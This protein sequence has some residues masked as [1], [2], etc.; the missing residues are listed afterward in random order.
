M[1]GHVSR[2]AIAMSLHGLMASLTR[3]V[4]WEIVAATLIVLGGV[5]VYRIATARAR[6]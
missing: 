6:R 5:T 3:I 4:G 2:T 1:S